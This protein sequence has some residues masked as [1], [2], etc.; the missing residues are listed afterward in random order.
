MKFFIRYYAGVL[1]LPAFFFTAT[2]YATTLIPLDLQQL[3]TRATLIFYGEVTGNTIK[4][5]NISGYI[6]TFTEFRIIEL[7]KGKAGDSH[8]IKQPGGHLTETN[9]TLRIHGVPEFETGIKYVVFLPDKSFLGFSSP[10]GLYQGSFQV[11]T[12]NGKKRVH[13]AR[14]SPIQH[15]M[16]T[17]LATKISNPGSVRLD[18]FISSVR[19]FNTP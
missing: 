10:L 3:S 11:T 19:A 8:T 14:L 15:N 1:I 5:D 2:V 18:D 6:A 12:E 7:I 16:Q 17:P 4:K 13:T 9:T